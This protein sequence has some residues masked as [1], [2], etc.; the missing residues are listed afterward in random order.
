MPSDVLTSSSDLTGNPVEVS[1]VR[2]TIGAALA[3]A[4]LTGTGGSAGS[5]TVPVTMTAAPGALYALV[6][7]ASGSSTFDVTPN[8][9]LTL[10]ISG[11]TPGQEQR[12]TLIIRQAATGYAVAL[13]AAQVVSSSGVVTAGVIYVGGM[14]AVGTTSGQATIIT[15]YTDDGGTTIFA[16]SGF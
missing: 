9:A 5:T 12:V 10:S 8:T 7:P 1:G 3:S 6:F 13:P 2:T 4:A 15:F 14:P 16:K 11:G